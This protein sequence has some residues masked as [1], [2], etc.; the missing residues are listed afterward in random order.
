MKLYGSIAVH[1]KGE[2][3]LRTPRFWD[4]FKRAFG[5]KP[6]LRTGHLR[7][8][9]E[10]TAIVEA[11]RDALRK[12][13]IHNAISLV[14][15]DTI[16]FHDREGK[17]DDLGDLFLAFHDN[18]SV[19]GDGFDEL[20]LAVEHREVGLHMVIELQARSEHPR[21]RPAI[22]IVL[23]GRIEALTPRPGED[24]EAY[25]KRAE[26]IATDPRAI[27]VYRLQFATFVDQVRD[28]ISGAL[29][30]ARVEVERAEPRIVR[31]DEK[32]VEPRAQNPDDRGYDPFLYYYPNPLAYAADALMWGALFS[33]A[34]QPHYVVVD[35]ANH[36]QGF[37]DDP[38]ILRGPTSSVDSSPVDTATDSW[39]GSDEAGDHGDQG[40]TGWWDS[41]GSD[42]SGGDFGGG[43]F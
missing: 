41:L 16:L 33:M 21:D 10:A 32:A 11:V 17:P 27:E 37:A 3:I 14:I 20:R 19:F 31:P 13:G 23:S 35:H 43:D 30:N 8:S 39:W 15:D 24:A 1:V 6:D 38:G 12:I 2:E 28:A 40:D 34:A 5:A 25:R 36:V 42:E 9:I 26:P 7:A 4:K 22:R 29:P 18:S